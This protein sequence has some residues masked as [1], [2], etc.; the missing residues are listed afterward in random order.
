MT[1]SCVSYFSFYIFD[2]HFNANEIWS[3]FISYYYG[4]IRN[5]LLLASETKSLI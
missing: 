2:D 1:L 4:D 5:F 3:F